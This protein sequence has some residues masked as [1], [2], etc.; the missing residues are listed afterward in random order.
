MFNVL[1]LG[2]KTK[3]HFFLLLSMLGDCNSILFCHLMDLIHGRSEG[4]N[5]LAHQLDF[6]R[7]HLFADIS[8]F[9]VQDHELD[10][11]SF[12]DVDALVE[13]FRV[14]KMAFQVEVDERV[15]SLDASALELQLILFRFGLLIQCSQA[16]NVFVV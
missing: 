3:T 10:L 16:T 14:K 13:T 4:A 2:I 8:D 6:D 9:P 5:L 12:T 1:F 7:G 11:V 15:Y